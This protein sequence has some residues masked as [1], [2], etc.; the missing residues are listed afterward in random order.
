MPEFDLRRCGLVGIRVA[1]FEDL[2]DKHRQADH[3]EKP[4]R[5]SKHLGARSEGVAKKLVKSVQHGTG[6]TVILGGEGK[7]RTMARWSVSPWSVSPCCGSLRFALLLPSLQV[8][9]LLLP[10]LQ[11]VL[12]VGTLLLPSPQAFVMLALST[13]WALDAIVRN[14]VFALPAPTGAVLHPQHACFASTPFTA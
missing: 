9:A 6:R 7:Q 8:I 10:S 13:G 5:R 11:A 1:A 2:A 4:G 12:M 14:L 3:Q